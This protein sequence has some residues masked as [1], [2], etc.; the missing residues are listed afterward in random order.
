MLDP[1][2]IQE[3][4]AQTVEYDGSLGN[5]GWLL[6][7]RRFSLYPQMGFK[8]AVSVSVLY[9]HTEQSPSQVFGF[10]YEFQAGKTLTKE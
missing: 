10:F 8:S 6:I 4:C 2:L 7:S 9:G 5:L 1:E 3:A